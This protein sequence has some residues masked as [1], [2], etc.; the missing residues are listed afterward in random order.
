MVLERVYPTG[1]GSYEPPRRIY[2]LDFSADRS[3]AG[4]QI[5]IAEAVVDDGL[6][7][8]DAAPAADRL[9]VGRER[10]AV[11]P[12]LA[13]FLAN[14]GG[15]TA[16][17]LDFPFGLPAKVVADDAWLEFLRQFPSWADD[18]ADLARESERRAALNGG[19]PASEAN[20][21]PASD[22]RG[23]S[24]GWSSDGASSDRRADGAG[25]ELLR[26][27]EEPLGAVSPYNERLRDETFYG[28][29]DLLR[30]LVL[31]DVVRAVPMQPMDADRPLLLEVYPT[32][33]LE[34]LDA[35]DL[36][37]VGDGDDAR[38]RRA[39]NLDVLETSGISIDECARDRALSDDEGDA[40]DAIVAA[41]AA[42]Q[43]TRDPCDL[44]TDDDVRALE[45]HIY[46]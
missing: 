41:V 35:H 11:L 3:R 2:G 15:G 5:W 18:P 45:G 6:R 32:G 1:M 19:G 40:L 17:G 30:P 26:A 42:Y 21:S 16:T 29:R 36:R 43:H 46:V 34:R 27:T 33:T 24:S 44:R 14:L 20:G 37:Y 8:V 10:E 9:D 7:V 12:A 22:V 39:A 31:A 25:T 4:E 28:I 23:T 38:Q 13:R